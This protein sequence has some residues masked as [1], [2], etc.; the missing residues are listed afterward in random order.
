MEFR[1]GLNV[2]QGPKG[3]KGDTGRGLGMGGA[4]TDS[5]FPGV[6]IEGPPGPPGPP[7]KKVGY[8]W[9]FISSYLW[10]MMV[11]FGT[12]LVL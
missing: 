2:Q 6:F 12:G 1:M 5:G 8:V 11:Y 3:E 9:P 7:G 4:S 10:G